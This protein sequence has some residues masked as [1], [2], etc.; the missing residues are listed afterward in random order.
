METN[1][2]DMFEAVVDLV[3]ERTAA[4]VVGRDRR[5][6]AELEDRVN[7]IA[8]HLEAAGVRPGEHVGIYAYNGMEWVETMLGLYKIRAVPV[9]INYRYVEAEL[10]YL[11]TNADLVAIVALREFAPRLAAIRGSLPKLR[12]VVIADDGSGGR[13]AIRA[14]HRDACQS[15]REDRGRHSQLSQPRTRS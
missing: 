1:F 3:P 14:A 15:G 10:Q 9:N 4:V 6:Y 5:T 2:A 13:G 7:R 8:H 11:C 12:H